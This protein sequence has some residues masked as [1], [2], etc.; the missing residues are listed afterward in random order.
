MRIFTFDNT[1]DAYDETQ[2]NE[3]I[4]D[5]DVLVVP[6]EN[7][8]GYLVQA[9]PVT[10]TRERGAFHSWVEFGPDEEYALSH[11]TAQDVA[12]VVGFALEVQA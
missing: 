10:V 2:T 11:S 7:V 5:G 6:S 4:S 1:S 12:R 9:W 8:V 3:E